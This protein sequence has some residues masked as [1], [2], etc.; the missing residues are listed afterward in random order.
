[1]WDERFAEICRRHPDLVAVYESSR[2]RLGL[3]L[4][5]TLVPLDAERVPWLEETRSA[6][7]RVVTDLRASGFESGTVVLQWVPLHDTARIVGRWAR[8]WDGDPARRSQLLAV[9]ERRLADERF[10]AERAT[11]HRRTPD[12]TVADAGPPA[13]AAAAI[14]ERL[15][16]TGLDALKAWY[17][18]MAPCWLAIQPARRRR[19]VLQAHVWLADVALADPVDG[20]PRAAAQLGPDGPLVRLLERQLPR[21]GAE[22]WRRWI[23]VV[24]ADL[25]AA[26]ARP[27]A[28]R[29]QAWARSLF[30]IPYRTVFPRRP[31]RRAPVAAWTAPARREKMEA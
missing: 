5:Q 16:E 29:S 11:H 18:A 6:V 19:L 31:R 7:R 15:D 22:A 1:V 4:R 28:L 8:R 24:R 26:L 21:R 30:F 3:L 14:G 20:P 9:V 13:P 23:E 10:L 12:P 17:G 27:A 2:G 25:A